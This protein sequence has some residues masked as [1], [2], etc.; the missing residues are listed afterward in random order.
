MKIC[1]LGDRFSTMWLYLR[2]QRCCHPA[3]YDIF[4][5]I[6]TGC[7]LLPRWE[8]KSVPCICFL[9]STISTVRGI[10]FSFVM[11][12]RKPGSKDKD[13]LPPGLY[14]CNAPIWCYS[15]LSL[16][17]LQSNWNEC[18]WNESWL[19][20]ND[21]TGT[22]PRHCLENKQFVLH[23]ETRTWKLP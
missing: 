7:K 20:S 18:D 9:R 13:A 23:V 22:F 10:L 5:Y 15:N 4:S 1:S 11:F 17:F 21:P 19:G 8:E 6:L 2:W 3:K 16:G 14:S 12:Y